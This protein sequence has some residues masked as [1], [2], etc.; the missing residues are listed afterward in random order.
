MQI[1]LW[2]GWYGL[3]LFRADTYRCLMLGRLTI[4]WHRKEVRP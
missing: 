1:E 2:P 3:G 4:S